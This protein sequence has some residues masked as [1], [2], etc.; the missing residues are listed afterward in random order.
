MQSNLESQVSTYY[1]STL[2]SNKDLKT[3][4][5][6]TDVEYPEHIKRILAELHDET[7]AKYYGC[8]LTIPSNLEGLKVLD[9]GSGSGRDCFILSKLV[10]ERG[11]VIGIDMTDEQVN[12]ARKH[13]DYHAAK[14]GFRN[15]EFKKG[16]IEKLDRSGI[17]SNSLDLIVSNCVINLASD[18]RAV[19]LGAYDLLK[20]GG[21]MYF[22]DVYADRRIPMEVANDP[23]I[24]GECLGGALYWN[25]FLNI[26]KS[27][28]F[29]DPRCVSTS[30]ISIEDKRIINVVGNINYYSVTYRLMKL[31]SLESDCE[32]YGQ[33]VRY[34]GTI[35]HEKDTFV[36]DDHHIFETGKIYTVC[37]N[38]FMMLHNTRFNDHFDFWGDFSTHYGI[39]EGCGGSAP[40]SVDENETNQSGSCC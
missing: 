36:L 2:Q 31:P 15:V 10:G 37:G 19:L 24:Y 23:E 39:F 11:S 8:G 35:S 32:D 7:M 40:F 16:N 28:G 38:T 33:A 1:G 34:K 14:F 13:I 5:C 26:A 3:N 12:V 4:A 29:G 27:I 17:E 9:L 20:E 18:K 21:E 6:C 22:S 30:N 25:D